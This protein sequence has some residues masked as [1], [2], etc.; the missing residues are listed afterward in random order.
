MM[1][2][3]IN[4]DPKQAD[5]L[6]RLTE[7]D[8]SI[9][10]TLARRG[11]TFSKDKTNLSKQLFTDKILIN[12]DYK[13][14]FYRMLSKESCRSVLKQ[15]CASKEGCLKNDL[16]RNR[17]T[18][19]VNQ[20]LSTLAKMDLLE[21]NNG[22]IFRLKNSDVNFGK[23]LE[24]FISEVF[25]RELFCVSDWG[26]HVKEAPEGGDYDVLARAESNIIYV[27]CKAKKPENLKEKELISFLKRDEFLRSYTSIL[28]IDSTDEIS[29]INDLINK[30][31]EK[32]K[33]CIPELGIDFVMGDPPYTESLDGGY[34]HFQGRLFFVNAKKSVL[35]TIK[36]CLR[37]RHRTGEMEIAFAGRFWLQELLLKAEKHL[38]TSFI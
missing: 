9:E 2:G 37:H 16:L 23:N 15:L 21:K 3:G 31:G 6:H 34:F 19:E 38:T 30:L 27:E 32:I 11:Y 7:E 10:K 20:L 8:K 35:D 24:W 28:F 36:L 22:E 1:M 13:D 26:V 18:Q 29:Y 5:A 25:H 4:I 33:T 14:T 17:T 12:R